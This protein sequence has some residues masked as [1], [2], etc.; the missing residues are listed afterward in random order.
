MDLNSIR[1][2]L[3]QARDIGLL[4]PGDVELHIQ[5]ARG[6]ADLAGPPSGRVLDLGSGGGVP[7]IVLAQLWPDAELTLLDGS[8][9]RTDFLRG[10]VGEL[11]LAGRVQVEHARAEV[12][13]H[14]PTLRG[15]F[16][17]V[18][19]RSFA[20]PAVTAECAAGFL[21]SKGRL[22]VSE[23]PAMAGELASES[24]QRWPSVIPELG[25]AATDTQV[26]HGYHFRVLTLV[27]VCEEKYPR[28]TGI[29]A[30]R[31]LF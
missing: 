20:R 13:G 5:H 1:A 28:R 23:P 12:A 26:S 4:G 15:S 16:A 25:L 14:S 11:G 19:S 3:V 31:P 30:K 22:I 2:V 27:G 21:M 18:V 29:P 6:F 24:D 7:G 17:I 9:K 10:A 8:E